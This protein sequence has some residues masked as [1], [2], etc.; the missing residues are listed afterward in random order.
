MVATEQPAH[1]VRVWFRGQVPRSEVLERVAHQVQLSFCPSPRTC[2]PTDSPDILPSRVIPPCADRRADLPAPEP[3]N[4]SESRGASS[5]PQRHDARRPVPAGGRPR[6][7]LC[8]WPGCQ[9]GPGL[10]CAFTLWL[11]LV[12]AYLVMQNG[13][14]RPREAAGA[15]L[16]PGG[17]GG[18]GLSG[19][20]GLHPHSGAEGH[21]PKSST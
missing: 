16:S 6:P 13:C 18:P 3:R 15:A 8:D 19:N 17:P 10:P 5:L 11:F 14:P 9:L 20:W 12:N 21:T 1:L 4:V 7:C 2:G